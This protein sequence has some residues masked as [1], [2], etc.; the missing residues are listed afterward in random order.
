MLEG[1]VTF[2]KLKTGNTKTIS[3]WQ[4]FLAM[5]FLEVGRFSNWCSGTSG[6]PWG[7]FKRG[8]CSVLGQRVFCSQPFLGKSRGW[9]DAFWTVVIVFMEWGVVVMSGD[10]S[11]PYY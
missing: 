11:I 9:W 10:F 4:V 3:D 5:G 7:L 1:R 8:E 2:T 6:C